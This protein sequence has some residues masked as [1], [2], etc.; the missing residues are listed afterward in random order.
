MG[1]SWHL[2][3]TRNSSSST[4]PRGWLLVTV[5]ASSAN[6]EDTT[7]SVPPGKRAICTMD[8]SALS[9]RAR[10]MSGCMPTDWMKPAPNEFSTRIWMHLPNRGLHQSEQKEQ[11]KLYSSKAIP[12]SCGLQEGIGTV[13]AEGRVKQFWFSRL[14]PLCGI[15]KSRVHPSDPSVSGFDLIPQVTAPQKAVPMTA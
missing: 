4:K 3:A 5:P 2:T 15:Y 1:Q 8:Q 11:T 12:C 13:Y 10:S 6:D 7:S 14:N 9:L